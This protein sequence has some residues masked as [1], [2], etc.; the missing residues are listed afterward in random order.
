VLSAY[1][2]G[3]ADQ[4]V[5]QTPDRARLANLG[6]TKRGCSPCACRPD[7]AAELEAQGV[8]VQRTV[9]R[10]R[11]RYHGTDTAL[12]VDLPL[13]S[14]LPEAVASIRKDFEHGY[15]RRFAFLMPSQSLVI[16][17]SRSNVLLPGWTRRAPATPVTAAPSGSTPGAFGRLRRPESPRQ[18]KKLRRMRRCACTVS[19]AKRPRAGVKRACP[20][21]GI[22]RRRAHRWTGHS[23]R[24][25]R[26]H[27]G[28]T[29][30]AASV[31]AAA[32]STCGVFTRAPRRHAAGTRVDPVVLE[33]F[34]N[35]FMNIAEQMDCAC[36][37]RPTR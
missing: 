21:R 14:S 25:Q 17:S 7:A 4:N 13:R 26:D 16:E 35:V 23:G 30:L 18:V 2:M 28:R 12:S 34:N 9:A 33:L 1:G 3:L 20:R 31:T 29:G 32:A 11:I 37:T 19:A 6:C 10:V 36:R 27:G 5:I 8:S 24:A 22:A 15:R